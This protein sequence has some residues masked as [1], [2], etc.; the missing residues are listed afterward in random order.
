MRFA[1]LFRLRTKLNPTSL[2]LL[3][4]FL[5]SFLILFFGNDY[6]DRYL[7]PGFL[8]LLLFVVYYFK[9][10]IDF[11]TTFQWFALALIGV[12]AVLHQHEFYTQNRLR[13]QQAYAI[14][15]ERGIINSIYVDGTYAKYFN[16]VSEG[17]YKGEISGEPATDYECYVQEYT[18]DANSAW[19]K[20]A[21]WVDDITQSFTE[22]PD[23]YNAKRNTGMP[24]I[25]NNLDKLIH[26]EPYF[27][28]E[29][30]LVGKEAWVGSWCKTSPGE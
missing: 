24:R 30:I 6:Y 8:S 23:V 2:F 29:N 27:S 20:V 26:N 5:G 15:H 14:Q 21:E 22:N 11:K 1:L 7:L 17:D 4:T 13:W 19:S 18:V 12:V 25:K 3:L 16:A 9:A 28:P 10:A